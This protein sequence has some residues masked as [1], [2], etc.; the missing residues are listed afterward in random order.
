V[1]VLEG[2]LF[3]WLFPEMFVSGAAKALFSGG[4]LLKI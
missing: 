4:Q 1:A 3:L 2:F